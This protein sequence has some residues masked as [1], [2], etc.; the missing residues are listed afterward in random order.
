M[1]RVLA[2]VSEH[3]LLIN[4]VGVAPAPRGGPPD[5][6]RGL[7]RELPI[8]HQPVPRAHQRQGVLELHAK[9]IRRVVVA[10]WALLVRGYVSE[11]AAP[12]A[13][14]SLD[15]LAEGLHARQSHAGHLRGTLELRHLGLGH[16]LVAVNVLLELVPLRLLGFFGGQARRFPRSL[17]L[18]LLEFIHLPSLPF[19]R[20]LLLALL[21]LLEAGRLLVHE[22][23]L[24]P[25]PQVVPVR[26]AEQLGVL[27]KLSP[28]LELL[29]RLLVPCLPR[30]LLLLSLE[31]P[32][33]VAIRQ[34][35]PKLLV[36]EAVA[37][38]GAALGLQPQLLRLGILSDPVHDA[39][40][41]RYAGLGPLEPLLRPAH[42]APTV[43]ERALL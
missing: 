37:P 24:L 20:L 21:H 26:L 3:H 31:K 25:V 4:T 2:G 27:E 16:D 23:E 11:T 12:H 7:E 40:R 35:M 28:L 14:H 39:P 41:R 13:L 42:G 34:R 32:L 38:R 19:I 30:L 36:Q 6:H 29:L 1:Q 10:L 33:L 15:L 22:G 8:L 43:D 17:L 9:L 18:A 5:R